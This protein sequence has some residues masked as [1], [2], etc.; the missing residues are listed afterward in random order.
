MDAPV[1]WAFLP[2]ALASIVTLDPR[3]VVYHCVDH[4]AANP[5]V[6]AAW[7]T[8]LEDAILTRADLVLGTSVPLVERLSQR[9]TD[10][11]LIEN[12]ADVALFRRAADESLEEPTTLAPLSRPRAIYAGN[13][14]RYRIEVEWLEHLARA[15]PELQIVLL[16][17]QGLGEEDSLPLADLANTHLLTTVPARELPRHLQSCDVAL[18]PFQDNDHT[19]SSFPL[20]FWEYV[21]AGL[22]VVS[23]DLDSLRPTAAGMDGVWLA[24]DAE[25]FASGVRDALS[26]PSWDR[27]RQS[28]RASGK[29]WEDRME[30]LDRYVEEALARRGRAVRGDQAS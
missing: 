1:L 5:G 15:I 2:T 26:I 17:P 20:K 29:G 10:V 23:R 30:Q 4:Y 16:G 27:K 9:R 3:L 12:V 11:R 28:D 24:A 7:I 14:A 22:P 25:S 18:I 13:L 19:R 6:D 8:S 21:A